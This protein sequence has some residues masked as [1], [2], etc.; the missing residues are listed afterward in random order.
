MTKLR[1]V[2]LGAGFGGLELTTMLSEAIGERIELT[3][4]DKSDSFAFGFSKLDVMFGHQTPASVR[5]EYR[6][7][8][9]PGVDFR[10]ETITAIDPVARRVTTDA[11]TYDADVLVV[12]LGADYDLAATPGLVEGGNEFYSFAGAERLREVLP[13]FTKGHAIVGVTSTPFKCPPA[14]SE[15]AL[16]LHDYLKQR[17]V[18][19]ACQISL[20]MPF[21]APVPPSPETSKALV[22]AFAERGIAWV[23]NR[24]VR[25]LDPAR[26]VAILDDDSDL[27]Y[28]LFL[29]VPKHRVPDV[30]AA[31]GMTEDGWIPVSRKNLETRFPEVYAVGDVNS[32]GTPKAGVFA[33]GAARVVAESLIAQA[34][35]GEL[36]SAYA[37]RGSCYVEFGA[38][39]VGRVDVDF[40][41][42]PSPTGTY[43]PASSALVAEKR[44]FGSSRRARWFGLNREL[45]SASSTEAIWH[46]REVRSALS[47]RSPGRRF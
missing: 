32:V 5:L 7:I 11:A 44:E 16:L 34:K 38:G 42:G 29:G 13:T 39:Q 1:V 46:V 26:R 18:R 21:G 37:G 47:P 20:V 43:F 25:A 6:N 14:P 35:N 45:D 17:G 24:L 2:V 8:V 28:D 40:M 9:K 3:L 27:P 36:P 19:D 4:I 22:T 23:P 33:E 41:S 15:A 31:S 12:A 30:V 10:Q